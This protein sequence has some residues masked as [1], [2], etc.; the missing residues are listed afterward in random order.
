MLCLLGRGRLI[1]AASRGAA[2]VSC[3]PES[4]GLLHGHEVYQA[5]TVAHVSPTA[6]FPLEIQSLLLMVAAFPSNSRP[7]LTE[8]ESRNQSA[9]GRPSRGDAVWCD[10]VLCFVEP[11]IEPAGTTTPSSL[12]NHRYQGYL[13]RRVF[14]PSPAGGPSWRY[15]LHKGRMSFYFGGSEAGLNSQVQWAGV[16]VKLPRNPP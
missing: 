1:S 2:V 14:S 3:I 5:F 6:T 10:V 11:R 8:I 16:L 12:K 4:L 15:P 9:E 13:N 7:W